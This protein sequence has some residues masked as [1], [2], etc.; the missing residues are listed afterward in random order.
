MNEEGK[1]PLEDESQDEVNT[2]ENLS[3]KESSEDSRDAQELNKSKDEFEEVPNRDYGSMNFESLV[4]EVQYLLSNYPVNRI[5]KAVNSIK[6]EF[7]KKEKEAIA[8]LKKEYIN[9]GGE[10]SGFYHKIQEKDKFNHI[11]SEYKKQI[12]AFYKNQ[13][14]KEAENLIKR[15]ALI[16]E[17]KALYQEPSDNNSA[18]FTTFRRI[19]SDWHDAGRVPSAHAQDIFRTFYHHLDNFYEYLKF[20]KELQE[21]DFEHNLK[22]RFVII[23]RANALLEEENIKKSLNEL[24]YLHKLWKEE[25]VPVAEEHREPTWNTFKEITQK[26]HDRKQEFYEQQKSV[27]LENQK[28]KERIIGLLKTV[29]SQ[30]ENSHKSIQQDIKK[31]EKIRK[32]FIAS[33]RAPRSINQDLWD[34]FKDLLKEFNRNKNQFYKQMKGQQSENLRKKQ[35]LLQKAKENADRDDWDEAVEFF[36]GIQ[37]EWKNVGMVPRKFSNEIWKEFNGICNTFFDRFKNR[38][39]KDPSE[40][41]EN[42]AQ[43]KEYLEN[44]NTVS[45][46][47]LDEEQVLEKAMKINKDWQSLGQVPASQKSINQD[48][49]NELKKK[50]QDTEVDIDLSNLNTQMKVQQFKHSGDEAQ[51]HETLRKLRSQM[52]DIRTDLGQLE[53]NLSF[54]ANAEK[55]NPM[56]KN[57]HRDIEAKKQ[58]LDQL[59]EEYNYLKNI[60]FE[61]EVEEEDVQENTTDTSEE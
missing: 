32:D 14:Q 45:F 53:T 50:I 6:R 43:K 37:R 27:E 8:K 23:E 56:L 49:K 26:I 29:L 42:L 36:K 44:L 54:F 10:E 21:M 48:F 40:L 28:E 35:E 34:E 60:R 19:K 17:L 41:N 61:E 20:N 11:I 5:S 58:R 3:S 55:D 2:S 18:L 22:T 16:E 13:E 51:L 25:A 47:G 7:F 46:E 39:Q 30:Q 38:N 4:A 15:Q 57:V 31:V 52:D 24:Q 12:S 1:N 59:Q 33:G 9:Q